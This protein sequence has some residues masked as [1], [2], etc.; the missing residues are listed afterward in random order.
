VRTQ[1]H[2]VIQADDLQLFLVFLAEVGLWS[3]D[4]CQRRW[5]KTIGGEGVPRGFLFGV[6]GVEQAGLLPEHFGEGAILGK[7]L[8][9][10]IGDPL[11]VAAVQTSDAC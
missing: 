7:V 11:L 1:P 4:W 2:P 6:A 10:H 9:I 3:A 5:G 8:N